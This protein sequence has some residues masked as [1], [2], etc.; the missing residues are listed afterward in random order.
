MSRSYTPYLAQL[1]D[2]SG[3]AQRQIAKEM[4]LPKP[5]FLSMLRA[6]EKLPTRRIPAFAKAVGV[7]PIELIRVVMREDR[8]DDWKAIEEILGPIYTRRELAAAADYLQ[9]L[10]EAKSALMSAN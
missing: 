4:G 6:G 10:D 7:E 1:M 5:N 9:R 2:D 8:P 3:K